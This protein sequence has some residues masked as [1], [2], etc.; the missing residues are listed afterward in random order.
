MKLWCLISAVV[1]VAALDAGA[2]GVGLQTKG[3]SSSSPNVEMNVS[4]L[5]KKFA[6]TFKQVYA[7]GEEEEK[8]VFLYADFENHVALGTPGR[9]SALDREALAEKAARGDADTLYQ[10]GVQELAKPRSRRSSADA[11]RYLRDASRQGHR[12]AQN[13]FGVL[14]LWGDAGFQDFDEAKRLLES[15]ARAGNIDAQFNLGYAQFWGMLPGGRSSAEHWFRKAARYAHGTAEVYLG[16]IALLN[17]DYAD[18][19][20]WLTRGIADGAASDKHRELRDALLLYGFVSM[21]EAR[22]IQEKIPRLVIGERI[23]GGL[24]SGV[25]IIGPSAAE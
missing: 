3:H 5:P 10:L 15:A 17:K 13:A 23:P 8:N 20:E 24:S 19:Y 25:S 21:R 9:T 16:F 18:C 2:Q 6:I 12:P 1:A 14:H 7:N 11:Y 22:R 4:L